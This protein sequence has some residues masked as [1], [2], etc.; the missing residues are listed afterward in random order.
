M[1]VADRRYSGDIAS[2]GQGQ[3]PPYP[4]LKQEGNLAWELYGITDEE[5]KIM[6]SM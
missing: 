3:P 1:A 5:R 6:E 2:T 4:L